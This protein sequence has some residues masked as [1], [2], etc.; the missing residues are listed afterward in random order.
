M[1]TQGPT[2]N[3]A[4]MGRPRRSA[5]GGYARGAATRAQIIAAALEVFG[6]Q[7]FEDTST[8]AIAQRAGV[9]LAALHYYF[10]GKP[11]LYHACAE[12]MAALGE[13]SV[14]PFVSLLR[15]ALV[16]PRLSRPD[17]LRLLH[18]VLDQLTDRLSGPRDPAAMVTFFLREQSE[19]TEAYEIIHTRVIQP[20]IEACS[21]VVG[22]LIGQPPQ[23]SETVLRTLAMLGPLMVFQ[24]AREGALRA[25][26]WPDFEAERLAA[27]KRVIWAQVLGGLREDGR[28][29]G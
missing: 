23:A 8:R 25:L 4:V 29:V 1:G 11:G 3:A 16:E 28:I 15:E 26:G 7:G 13:Q 2:R 17:L 18:H 6:A 27:V 12:H 9:N 14:M 22:R 19:P 24:R 21:A 20:M 5:Q 10:G